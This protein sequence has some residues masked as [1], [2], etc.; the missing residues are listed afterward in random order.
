[1]PSFQ[2][3]PVAFSRILTIVEK[4]QLGNSKK[5][6]SFLPRCSTFFIMCDFVKRSSI[7][8][9]SVQG[10]HG[11]TTF[12]NPHIH[13]GW[14]DPM[15]GSIDGCKTLGLE[16]VIWSWLVA[17]LRMGMLAYTLTYAR[18]IL[19]HREVP[20]ASLRGESWILNP[21]IWKPLIMK[22]DILRH[23]WLDPR[24]KLIQGIAIFHYVSFDLTNYTATWP[25][26][27]L[28][29]LSPVQCPL[30]ALHIVLA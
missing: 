7:S 14:L 8:F 4:E 27:G 1:M 29:C 18:S 17:L 2:M 5:W 11:T 28:N 12:C 13:L 16:W 21:R 19:L 25:S 15:E 6:R 26:S 9:I 30:V 3:S 20:W 23:F 22:W 10:T 24:H